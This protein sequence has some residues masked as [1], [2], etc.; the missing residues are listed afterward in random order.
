MNQQAFSWWTRGDWNGFFGLFTNIITNLMVIS[1]LLLFAVGIPGSIVFGRVM[2]AIG[3]AM[4]LGN[5]Y[6]GYA[7]RKL[8][9]K[10]KRGDVTALPYGPSVGHIFIVTFLIIG[11]VYWQTGDPVLA[12]RVG[13]AWCV[14]E[15]VIEILGF[16]VGPYIRKHTPRASMLAVLAGLSITLIAMRAVVESWV[17]PYIAFV[18]LGL[19]LMGWLAGKKLPGNIPHG[20]AIIVIG[21]IIGWATGYM[22]PEAFTSA[23]ANMSV[24]I[25]TFRFADITE[26]FGHILP[27]LAVAIPLGIGNAI[28]T[29]NNIESAAAA[30]DDY[31]TRE[32][33]IVDGV[34]SLIGAFMGSPFPTTV[35]IGH[36]GWKNVG[37]RAGYSVATGVC[38]L[39]VCVLGIIPIFLAVVPLVA[40]L[41]ILLYIGLVMGAQA[42]QATPKQHAPAIVLGILPW[43]ALWG[44][45]QV[46][47]AL[48]AAGTNAYEVGF[49][50]LENAGV[51]Y[52]GMKLLSNGAIISSMV[53]ASIAVYVIDHKFKH[54][55]IYAFSGAVFSFFG[56]IYA[57]QVGI[58]AAPAAMI[59]YLLISAM[60]FV[61]HFT[62]AKEQEGQLDAGVISTKQ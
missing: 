33:M 43:I 16:A 61:L 14:I 46:D 2:P 41:P 25:P 30:G 19:V 37:A 7:A 4:I 15:A 52:N 40:V 50:A 24:A 62:S 3:V 54:A 12:W 26:G 42:F 31:D 51:L 27:F 8:A 56:L 13:L 6:Y 58:N 29:L 9:L 21:T 39:L 11:P 34:G 38:T 23:V 18:C 10:E 20:L 44:I 53:I 55:G 35:Y 1:S 36:V 47:N 45:Q 59:G 28:S 32:C 48:N 17:V 49:A 60:F 22:R 5:V 57:N